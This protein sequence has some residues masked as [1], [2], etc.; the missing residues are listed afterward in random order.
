MGLLG[1]HAGNSVVDAKA[2]FD[3]AIPERI[4]QLVAMG[5]LVAI[6]S[7]RDRGAISIQLTHD[8]DWEREYFRRADE[9]T[10]WLDGAIRTLKGRGIGS[11]AG[12]ETVTQKPRRGRSVAT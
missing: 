2:F 4:S 3:S 6:G 11:T 9:A 1:N 12:Q 10:E 5:L 7:T 8:G